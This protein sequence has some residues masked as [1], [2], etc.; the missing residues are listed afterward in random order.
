MSNLVQHAKAIKAQIHEDINYLK[1][2]D[3][4]PVLSIALGELY[5]AQ[6]KNQLYFLGN[7]LLNYSAAMKNQNIEAHRTE[8]QYSLRENYEKSLEL[9]QK[10]EEKLKAEAA[11]MQEAEDSLR[12]DLCCSM[13]VEDLLPTIIEFL[14]S[15]AFAA[16]GY[17]GLQERMKRQITP[18]DDE[19]AHIDEESPLVIR[20]ITATANS[21]FML[22]QILKEEEGQATWSVWKE[23]EEELPD[24]ELPQDE[25]QKPR[26]KVV[27]VDDVVTD[28]RIKFFDVPKLGA[29]LA[30]PLTCRTCLSEASF[31]AGVD[32]ATECRKLRAQQEE[33]KTKNEAV[34]NE[35]E[36]KVYEEVKENPYRTSEIRMVVA[37]DTLGQDRTFN[38]DQK[39]YVIDWVLMLRNEWERA[40]N[41]SLRRDIAT[42]IPMRDR[43]QQRMHDKQV[44]WADEEKNVGDE[45]IRLLHASTPDET[46]QFEALQAV[47]ELH[48]RRVIN[49]MEELISFTKF[50]VVKY[51]RVFQIGLYLS[52]V[53][54]EE[55]VEPGTNMI[56][57]KKAKKFVNS[58]FQEFLAAVKPCGANPNKPQIYAKTLKLESDLKRIPFEEVQNYSVSMGILYRFLEQ[59]F[60][61]RVVD[62]MQRRRDYMIKSEKREA[63]VKAAEELDERRKKAVDDAKEVYEKE[64]EGI[65]EGYEKPIFEIERILKEFDEAEGNAP[66][67][68]PPE[69]IPDED[70]DIDW[71]EQS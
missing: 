26:V 6:P 27:S 19:K 18:L 2:D 48:R 10:T 51:S 63:A 25:T 66:V 32:D 7:W 33:E 9:Q 1:Q 61:L 68:I 43:D 52:G 21:Q 44:E 47:F 54:R 17:I 49:E 36:Q 5:L 69:I 23:D 70:G 71:E 64:I 15:R 39:N 57:W 28:P 31:D 65:E 24:E 45:A 38:E 11:L 30:V 60:R 58:E 50:K 37:L 42:Y 14:K 56:F 53:L 3:I 59:Y 4:S 46:K 40:E 41:E 67:E 20:Y 12:S 8:I 62:V 29:Y 35:E 13:D 55:V 22:D 34:S 16:A